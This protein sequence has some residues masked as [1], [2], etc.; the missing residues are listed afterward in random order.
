SMSFSTFALVGNSTTGIT[1]AMDDGVWSSALNKALVLDTLGN[2]LRTWSQGEVGD[3]GAS[4]PVGGNFAIP[5][6]EAEQIAEIA[7]TACDGAWVPYSVGLKGK[8]D[9]VPALTAD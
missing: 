1:Y 7:P 4:A 2:K 3:G 6:G 5:S 9:F 8:G